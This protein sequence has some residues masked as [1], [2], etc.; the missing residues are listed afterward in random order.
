MAINLYCGLQGSGKTYESVRSVILPN[1]SAGR[2]VVSNV[3]GLNKESIYKYCSE[4]L[5]SS[6]VGELCLVS[7]D[8]IKKSNFFCDD[9]GDSE[10]VKYG[11]I[12]VIDEAWKFWRTEKELT[13]NAI[14]FFGMQRHYGCDLAVLN[15]TN[16]LAKT[17]LGRISTSF[18]TYRASTLGFKKQYRVLIYTGAGLYKT[19]FVSGATHRYKDDIFDLY[20]SQQNSSSG[21]IDKRQSFFRSF[22]Y[23]IIATLV[24]LPLLTYTAYYFS[25]SKPLKKT[26]SRQEIESKIDD[27]GNA[28]NTHRVTPVTDA[29]VYRYVGAYSMDIYKFAVLRNSKGMLLK[30]PFSLCESEGRQTVCNYEN[31]KVTFYTGVI[32]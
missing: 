3:E 26:E 6:S 9:N 5:K 4:V 24:L 32:K 30:I 29:E 8:D 15:Q 19:D 31:K 21:S 11:D 25:F 10:Y 28:L 22:G 14:N 27:S 16:D 18:K 1:L 7:D 2:R 12:C 13:P 17:L 23:L 20:T